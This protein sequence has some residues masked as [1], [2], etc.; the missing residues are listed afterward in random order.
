[1]F[2]SPAIGLAALIINSILGTIIHNTQR[3]GAYLLWGG[4]IAVQILFW[5]V[6]LDIIG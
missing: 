6:A 3:V 2:K 1:M 5:L 4:A